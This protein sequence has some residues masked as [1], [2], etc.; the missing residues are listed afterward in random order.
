MTEKEVDRLERRRPDVF[1][2]NSEV[3]DLTH[4][5]IVDKHLVIDGGR[6]GRICVSDENAEAFLKELTEIVDMYVRKGEGD[7]TVTDYIW[8]G[9]FRP[10]RVQ[11]G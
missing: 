3:N 6:C 9:C 10:V 1:I 7:C 5:L 8:G 11:S 4:Y 2:I